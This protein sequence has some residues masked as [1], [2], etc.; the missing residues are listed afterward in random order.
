MDPVIFSIIFMVMLLYWFRV[1]IQISRNI[2]YAIGELYDDRVEFIESIG[3]VSF[4]EGIKYGSL[5]WQIYI[6]HMQMIPGFNPVFSVVRKVSLRN[7]S[8][9]ERLAFVEVNFKGTKI[10]SCKEIDSYE[11]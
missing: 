8:D 3:R 7:S 5:I 1:F 10:I 4:A 9:S 6:P 2:A 11:L